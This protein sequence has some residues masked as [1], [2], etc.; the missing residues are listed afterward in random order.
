MKIIDER[1]KE[2]QHEPEFEILLDFYV[3]LKAKNV[4][5]IGSYYGA[6]LHHWLHYSNKNANVVSIDLPIREFCGPLDPRCKIQ[7]DAIANEWKS[8]TKENNNKL[9]LIQDISQKESVVKEVHKL[10]NGSFFDFIFIDGNHMYDAVKRDFELYTPLVR[11][12]GIIALHDIGYAEEGGVHRLWDEIKAR[13][14][15]E[16]RYH[17]LRMHPDKQKGIGII[18]T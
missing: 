12:G 4:L 14:T 1:I 15:Y 2:T 13:N 16:N 9:Y 3:K 6:S 17:E 7:E 8:W 18:V 5:E 10:L 11:K